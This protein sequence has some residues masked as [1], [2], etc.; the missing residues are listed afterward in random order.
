MNSG[1]NVKGFAEVI[2]GQ[3]PGSQLSTNLSLPEKI[4]RIN[5]AAV[6]Y[7]ISSDH[8]GKGNTTFDIWLTNKK[9]PTVFG[10]PPITHEIM[11][12]LESYGDMR[13]AGS[14]VEQA[15][16]DGMAYNVF[17]AEHFGQGWKYVA[18]Q[19]VSSRMGINHIDLISFLSYLRSK[20]L[21]TGEEYLASIE[22]G[23][24]VISGAGETRLNSYAIAMQYTSASSA[25]HIQSRSYY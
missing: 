23:N 14:F 10:V 24:E 2:Y 4:S 21:I 18:F 7:D 11:I 25:A 22:L 5:V 3:K 19:S 16:I 20:G 9:N 13:P 1:D 12:W 8:T 15:N 17:V 6:N